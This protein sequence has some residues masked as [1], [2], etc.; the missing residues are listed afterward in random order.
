MRKRKFDIVLFTAAMLLLCCSCQKTTEQD[1]VQ[2]TTGKKVIQ[3]PTCTE[4]VYD[5]RDY[6]AVADDTILSTDAIN[7]AAQEAAGV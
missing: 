2:I 7:A 1:E 4:N 5:I 6:G 3:Y